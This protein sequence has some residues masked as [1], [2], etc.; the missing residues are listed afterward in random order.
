MLVY[1]IEILITEG[2]SRERSGE[3][4]IIKVCLKSLGRL[5]FDPSVQVPI[6][7]Q[8]GAVLRK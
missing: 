1:G 6:R 4:L 5:K 3:V 8:K 7:Q 2:D